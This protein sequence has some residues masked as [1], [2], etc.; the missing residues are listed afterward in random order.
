LPASKA[1]PAAKVSE[2]SLGK[3]ITVSATAYCNCSQCCGSYAGSKTASGTMP[4]EMRTIAASS[5]YAFG[6][7]VYIP[8]FKDKPNAGIFVVEDRGGA[9]Q[10]N[11]IDIF[12]S[13]HAKAMAFGRRDIQMYVVK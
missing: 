13:T 2:D 6:T 9:I 7:K 10:G 1:A 4:Q 11:K 12:F 5:S 8:Y 3:A